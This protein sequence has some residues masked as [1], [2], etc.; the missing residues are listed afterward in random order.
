MSDVQ[1][2]DESE[3]VVEFGKNNFIIIARKI[4]KVRQNE[5]EFISLSRGY[6]TRDGQKKFV[7]SMS[8]PLE[9]GKRREL[10]K[11]IVDI[12]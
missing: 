8:L 12:L 9:I 7:K 1:Y 2:F 6:Y 11:A 5:H 4:A 10:A 3:I